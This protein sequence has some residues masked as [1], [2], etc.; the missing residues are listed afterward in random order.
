[1]IDRHKNHTSSPTGIASVVN[2]SG[3]IALA[4]PGLLVLALA[5]VAPSLRGSNGWLYPEAWILVVAG[6]G[7][8]LMGVAWRSRWQRASWFMALALL[9]Q[10]CALSMILAPNYNILQHY[11]P[12]P[13]LL[14]YPRALL[15]L[16]PLAQTV[17]VGWAAWQYRYTVGTAARRIVSRFQMLVIV[18]ILVFGAANGSFDLLRFGTEIVLALWILTVNAANLALV[19]AAVPQEA[20]DATAKW[21]QQRFGFDAK[22]ED[23]RSTAWGRCLPGAAALWVI[24]FS[25]AFSWVVFEG[26]PHVPDAVSYLFQ[27]KYLSAGLLYLPSPPDAAAFDFEKLYSDGTRWFAYGFPGWPGVLSLGL[28]AGAPWLVNPLLAGATV[29][30]AHSLVARL[31]NR[32]LAHVVILLLAVS[33]WFLFMSASFMPHPATIV[34]TLVAL[35]AVVKAQDSGR[36]VWGLVAGASLGALFLTR[37]LEAVFVGAAIGAWVLIPRP[38]LSLGSL[39]FLVAGGLLVGGLLFLYNNA[40][41]GNPLRTPH[42]VMTDARYYPGADRLGFGEEVGAYGWRQL[43]PLPGH[44]PIDVVLNAHMNFF[45]SNVELFGWGFGSVGFVALLILWRR[46]RR[47]DWLFLLIIAAIIGGHSLFWFSGGPDFGARYWYQTL[48]PLVVLTARGVREARSRWVAKGG[49]PSG[50]LRIG[51]F[52]AAA[53]VVALLTFVP[54]RSLEKYP[55]YRGMNTDLAQLAREYNFE[56]SLV[57]VQEQEPVDYA[58]ALILN[59]PTL[60]SESTIYARDLGPQSRANLIQH[61]PDREVWIVRAT[62]PSGPYELVA[63]PLSSP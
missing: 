50:A 16:G 48:I 30:L 14:T 54:W 62:A 8:G 39:A 40:L 27:A 3:R 28:L 58:R 6:A 59:P 1:M 55:D 15:L 52:V 26:I 25:A 21:L 2:N 19:A 18:G 38:R 53:S 10:A 37:P 35:L 44:G 31:Y 22:A 63:G 33:P 57:F 4:L 61:F 34:W 24:A 51:A 29:L 41:T 43:D 20:L 46:T 56:H 23:G 7:L 36:W 11:L 60:D 32:S 49:S 12:W 17:I 47:Q 45:M 9:G 13:E 42:Q 5:L